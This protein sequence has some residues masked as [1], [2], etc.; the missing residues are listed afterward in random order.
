MLLDR[1]E[2]YFFNSNFR[3]AASEAGWEAYRGE[4]IVIEGE[5][6]DEQGRRKP[7]VA[8]F[9]QAIVLGQ[10]DELKLLS[11][12]LEELQHW[13]SLMEKFGSGLNPSTVAVMFTVN[14]PKPFVSVIN[15]AT[16]AFIPLTEGLCWNEL[17]DLVALEKGDFKGQGAADKVLTVFNAFKGHKFK[18]PELSVD[19]ALKTTNN[20]KRETHGAV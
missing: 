8:L 19:E 5:V 10:G 11:G 20:A 13:P 15:G 18:Y 9:K 6:A 4:L 1:Y 7:P 2:P 12:S 17:I 14:I 3:E 16:V